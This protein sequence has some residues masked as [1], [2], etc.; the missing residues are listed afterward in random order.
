MQRARACGSLDALLRKALER[1]EELMPPLAESE[2]RKI[3]SS[4]W[5]YE[6]E[7]RNF[8]GGEAHAILPLQVI[9]ALAA[10]NPIALALFCILRSLHWDRKEFVIA[11][12][13]AQA[14][15]WPVDRLRAARKALIAAGI[16]RC[17]HTGGRGPGDPPR[18]G[19][20]DG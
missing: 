3:A 7:G 14:L 4:A 10:K 1:N 8:I 6:A 16:I 17:I 15:C 11:N 5:N 19:W 12:A 13:M 2:V 18:Y 20:P 9:G